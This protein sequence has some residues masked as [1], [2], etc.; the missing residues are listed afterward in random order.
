MD[1]T[2]CY[3]CDRCKTP[4][5]IIDSASFT[6]PLD[7]QWKKTS[8]MYCKPECAIWDNRLVIRPLRGIEEWE[9]REAWFIA[10]YGRGNEEHE[11]VNVTTKRTKI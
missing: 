6:I 1:D 5:N 11:S 7:S 8:G 10:R 4:I 2:E 3:P 9:E